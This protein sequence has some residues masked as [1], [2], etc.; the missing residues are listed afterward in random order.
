MPTT[1]RISWFVLQH[2]TSKA[3]FEAFVMANILLVGAATGVELDNDGRDERIS[4]A[5]NA[6]SLFTLAV[7]TLEV[8]LKV[9][10]EA[11][12]PWR[13]LT[14]ADNGSFNLFDLSIVV[15][16]YAFLGQGGGAVGGL[17]MLRLVRLLTFVKNVPQLRVIVAGLVQVTPPPPLFTPPHLFDRLL[18]ALLFSPCDAR[19]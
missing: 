4:E 19:A 15:A 11:R 12:E 2:F 13:Y 5:V 3:W 1:T 14:D 8:V 7:F 9:V 6:V 16:S 17:R 18:T 10:A